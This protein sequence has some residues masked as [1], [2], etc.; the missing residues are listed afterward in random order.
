[1]SGSS[2]SKSA[3]FAMLR[4]HV[5]RL[6][7]GGTGEIDEEQ[8]AAEPDPE[9]RELMIDLHKLGTRLKVQDRADSDAPPTEAREVQSLVFS[10]DFIR[11]VLDNIPNSVFVKDTY[12]RFLMV[13]QELSDFYGL[14]THEFVNVSNR[15]ICSDSSA[16]EKFAGVDRQVIDNM[17]TITYEESIAR[18]DGSMAWYR[19]TKMPVLNDQGEVCLLGVA[20]DITEHKQMEREL[21]AAKEKAEDAAAAR[22]R[23]LANISHEMRTPL[24]G[25]IGVNSLLATSALDDEQREFV[26]TIQLSSDMLLS[27]INDV[28]D[29]SKLEYQPLTLA[30]EPFDLPRMIREVVKIHRHR[31]REKGLAMTCEF[32]SNLPERIVGDRD[33]LSQVLSNLVGNAVKFTERG[34]VHITAAP[35]V[36]SDTRPGGDSRTI[37]FCVQDTG[38]GIA[39]SKQVQLFEPFSQLDDSFTRRHGGTG[40]GLTIS[41]RLVELMDGRIWVESDSGRGASF[42]FTVATQLAPELSGRH[43]GDE[44]DD[45]SAPG[46]KEFKILVADD[47]LINQKVMQ[48][49]LRR[50]GQRSVVV[51]NGVEA[52]KALHQADYDMVFMDLHMP[53]MDGFTA[54]W[55]IQDDFPEERRP[56]IVAVTADA[57]HGD[58]E[59]CLAAGMQDYL[60]KPVTLNAVRSL[61]ERWS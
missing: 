32:G 2:G 24:N 59:R 6:L 3:V 35:L 56:V 4:R 53:E 43:E 26:D 20:M 38:I 27:L 46:L 21:I 50:L 28:L 34:S 52:L 29:F 31:A 60:S 14:P 55:Y 48:R 39:K 16:V 5:Q 61:L 12:G 54:A 19:T 41:K 23:F 36:A 58:R 30:N 1:M 7:D 40:L 11:R 45:S 18:E 57:M 8:I 9:V 47:N 51:D 49:L 17:E 25:I 10:K 33:R 42:F 22:S 44:P 37:R 15:A 13:N